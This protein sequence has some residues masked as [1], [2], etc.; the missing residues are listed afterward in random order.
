MRKANAERIPNRFFFNLRTKPPRVYP[1]GAL[2]C[3]NRDVA[4]LAFNAA[5]SN[6][7][8]DEFR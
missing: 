7:A 3:C 8:D 6:A 5:K 2:L 1:S 4:I